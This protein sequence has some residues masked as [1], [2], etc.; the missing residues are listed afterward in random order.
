MIG[1]RVMASG[2]KMVD[3]DETLGINSL[4]RGVVRLWNTLARETVNAPCL[5]FSTRLD[6]LWA[7]WYRGKCP[8]HGSRAG[9]MS[10]LRSL[11]T[12]IIPRFY[13]NS[14]FDFWMDCIPYSSLLTIS[15]FICW[16]KRQAV[17]A[18]TYQFSRNTFRHQLESTREHHRYLLL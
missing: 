7:I 1:Q 18:R 12:Q 17:L 3:L 13:D 4:L 11:S 16:Q 9:T 14:K 8:T 6:G 10:S 2:E 15:T 5:V